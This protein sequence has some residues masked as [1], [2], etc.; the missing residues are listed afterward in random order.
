[1]RAGLDDAPAVEHDDGIGVDNGGQAVG[2]DQD[3][4]VRGEGG[5]RLLDL[6]LGVRVGVGGGLVEQE[7][8]GVGEEGAGDGDALVVTL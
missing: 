5:Q 7:D 6:A 2:D 4:A 8:R 1:M 3:G